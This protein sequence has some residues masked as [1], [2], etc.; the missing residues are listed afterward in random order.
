MTDLC[1]LDATAAL[2]LLN[3]REIAAVDLVE[4]C[5]ARIA[6]DDGDVRAFV[7]VD[8]E[9]ALARARAVDAGTAP[10]GPLR[11]LPF[12][13]KDVIDVA[14]LST[15][16]GSALP[17]GRLAA[18]DAAVVALLR[19]AGGIPLGKTETVEFAANGRIPPTRN[20]RDL[21][22][23]PGGS[24]S[25]SAAAVAA[26]MVPV[27]LGTQT[28]GSLVRP[29]SFTGIY[30]LKPSHGLVSCDGVHPNAPSV[31]CVG[32]H[33]R[34]V[35]DLGLLGRV[36]HLPPAQRPAPL[37]PRDLRIAVCRTPEWHRVEADGQR[38]FEAAAAALAAAGVTV[39]DLVLPAPFDQL[40]DAHFAI[41]CG[42][43]RASFRRWH[44]AFGDRLHPD[45]AALYTGDPATAAAEL[46]AARLVAGHCRL[47]HAALAAGFDAILAPATTGEAPLHDGTGAGS[48]MMN[49][50]WS[51]LQVPLVA[52]P[53]G[54]GAHGL[55]IGGQLVGRFAADLDL[56]A[57]AAV[58]DGILRDASG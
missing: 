46:A 41:M 49:R 21:A 13:V 25:G 14:G 6:R 24:S 40:S 5:L 48:P 53:A 32:W 26:G 35:A 7:E 47:A 56:V 22:R 18:T 51:A 33:A 42:E 28:G 12:A 29:A 34:S 58:V 31:D 8:A 38:V 52:L 2:A 43:G 36:L 1:A 54:L 9:G 37:R 3:R 30:A 39:E 55:P 4:A 19:R 27:S 23:T 45:L 15:A 17:I 11:G 50:M 10:A 44:A 16:F 20:P 57:V